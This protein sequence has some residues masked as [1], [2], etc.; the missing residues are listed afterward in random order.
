MNEA[1][2]KRD[3]KTEKVIRKLGGAC[4]SLSAKLKLAED[5]EKGY[6]EAFSTEK[7]KRNRNQP[8]TEELRAEEGVSVPFFSPSKVQ[9]AREL[10]DA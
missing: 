3:S 9:K 7:M 2:A 8:F 1:V 10:Q 5:L 6:L 4:L